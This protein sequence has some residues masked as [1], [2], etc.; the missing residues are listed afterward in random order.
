MKG[1]EIVLINILNN[2]SLLI[3]PHME[4]HYP[5]LKDR[6]FK[7]KYQI[8]FNKI[9]LELLSLIPTSVDKDLKTPC[10]LFASKKS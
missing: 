1:G 3:S 2:I 10:L 9:M 7:L 8:T 4:E 6:L 5:N